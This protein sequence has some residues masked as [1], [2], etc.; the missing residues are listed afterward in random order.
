MLSYGNVVSM[1]SQLRCELTAG[2]SGLP[3]CLGQ[4]VDSFEISNINTAVN[5]F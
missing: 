5:N 4:K 1:R 3:Q 2:Q